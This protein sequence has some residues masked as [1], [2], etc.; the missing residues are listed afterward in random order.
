MNNFEIVTAVSI[1]RYLFAWIEF[2]KVWFHC[3]HIFQMITFS[4]KND[5]W[6]L[7][8][9]A[10]GIYFWPLGFDQVKWLI[11]LPLFKVRLQPWMHN[12]KLLYFLKEFSECCVN[13]YFGGKMKK[14]MVWLSKYFIIL[15]LNSLLNIAL[16]WFIMNCNNFFGK[17]LFLNM[18]LNKTCVDIC[19]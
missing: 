7:L 4:Q 13:E 9:G 15:L 19:M 10:R 2:F 16:I 14:Y 3:Q 6:G 17:G 5:W 11:F 18:C 1:S 8:G 12:M